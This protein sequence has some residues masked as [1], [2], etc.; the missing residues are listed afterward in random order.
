MKGW[1]YNRLVLVEA[2]HL[3]NGTWFNKDEIIFGSKGLT[4]FKKTLFMENN[5]MVPYT[6]VRKVTFKEGEFINTMT[7][8][9]ESG[10][11]FGL[12]GGS[13]SFNIRMLDTFLLVKIA[14]QVEIVREFP[15]Y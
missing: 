3:W 7:I 2:K 9:Y 4:I 11:L 10:K 8:D 15:S 1:I 6:K 14:C 12:L 13:A 5:I